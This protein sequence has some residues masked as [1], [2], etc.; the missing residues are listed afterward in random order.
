M[1]KSPP[2]PC[3]GQGKKLSCH[4]FPGTVIFAEE[5]CCSYEEADEW[6][7]SGGP[8]QEGE[9]MSLSELLT[10]TLS[11]SQSKRPADERPR[12][13]QETLR[14]PPPLHLEPFDHKP[15]S[16]V[17]THSGDSHPSASLSPTPRNAP[18][19]G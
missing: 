10:Y 13:S 9:Q 1:R 6:H 14:L 7:Q 12:D 18:L 4:C 16:P 8:T 15:L 11:F 2:G 19:Y 5:R 17:S 3:A